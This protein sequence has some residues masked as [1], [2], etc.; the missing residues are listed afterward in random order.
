MHARTFRHWSWV[1]FSNAST[2][3][4]LSY[5]VAVIQWITSCH[6]NHMT[7]HVIILWCEHVMS[8]TTSVSTVRFRIELMFIL[9]AIKSHFKGSYNKQNRTFVVI[10]YEI[11]ETHQRLVS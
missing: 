5:D 9:K 6:K 4:S 11:Y 3:A 2:Y 8:L 1:Y 10:S 7:T